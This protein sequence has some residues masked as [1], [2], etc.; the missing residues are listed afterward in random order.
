MGRVYEHQ[1]NW[2]RAM[3]CYRKAFKTNG[4]YR[5]ALVGYRRLQAMCN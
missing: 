1:H 2:P 5:V 3:E 4:Q